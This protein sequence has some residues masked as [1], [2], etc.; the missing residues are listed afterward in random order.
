MHNCQYVKSELSQS[1]KAIQERPAN[2]TLYRLF[3]RREGVTRNDLIILKLHGRKL[4]SVAGTMGQ[5][6]P[7]IISQ[8]AY[9]I[10]NIIIKAAIHAA[11]SYASSSNSE[12]QSPLTFFALYIA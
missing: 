10:L 11:Q 3:N 8:F 2:N 5:T 6:A 1:V 9:E 12:G 4:N 7:E